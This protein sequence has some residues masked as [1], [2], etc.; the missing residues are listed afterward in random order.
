V[1]RSGV[2]SAAEVFR[3]GQLLQLVGAQNEILGYGLFEKDGLI[4]I[5]VLKQGSTPP[6]AKWITGR[7]EKA[8][9]K[10]AQVRKYSN[11]FRAIHGENDGLP[12]VVVDVYGETAVLQ[13]YAPSVDAFGR[14]IGAC[15]CAQ[16][17]LKNLVWKLPV[18]RKLQRPDRVLKGKLVSEVKV[19]EGK[20]AITIPVGEG[21]KSGAF[22]D[23]RGLRKWLASQKLTGQKVLNLFS[24]TG[25][26]GLAAE[27]GGAKEIWNVDISKGALE[28]AK[29]L[30]TL[31]A[32]KHRFVCADIFKWYA[33]LAPQ[34]KFDLIIVDPPMM[35]S[36]TDQ[37]ETALRAYR[38]L[39]RESLSHLAP[40]GRLVMCCCTSRI[41]RGK[42][43]QAV[44]QAMGSHLKKVAA[45]APEDDHPVG[46]PEGD[47][48]KIL[49]Y[50]R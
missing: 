35:A 37:V 16:L 24:Y 31:D 15:V 44:A 39:Y 10:R 40:R 43:E 3:S 23:L 7:V 21:Q 34:E 14:Y 4:A 41:S 45:I 46:F 6:D 18:K 25:T 12:G 33:D 2:S 48:L 38:K 5:R 9:T 8:L 36:R 27:I 32:K 19:A 22:L 50:G 11:A 42:F 17:G 29:R 28:V 13:T 1:Y 30:H 26:L 20:L 49:V 47:Y